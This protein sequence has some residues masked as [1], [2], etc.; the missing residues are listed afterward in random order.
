M[1]MDVSCGEMSP[2]VM[3]SCCRASEVIAPTVNPIDPND[4]FQHTESLS[5]RLPVQ[6]DAIGFDPSERDERRDGDFEAEDLD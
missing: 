4:V 1:V 6:Q 2:T 5:R 3:V